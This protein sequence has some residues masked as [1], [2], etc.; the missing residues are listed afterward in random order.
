MAGPVLAVVLAFVAGSPASADPPLRVS[1]H[2]TQLERGLICSPSSSG[3]RDAPD[4][5]AGWIHVPD[6][7]LRIIAPS[8]SAPAILGMGF[9]VEFTIAGNEPLALRYEVTHPPMPPEGRT[10]QAWDGVAWPDS[11]EAIFFLFDI[12]EELQPGR[13]S[14]TASH[15]GTEIF[16]AE[17]DVVAPEAAPHLT[18]LCRD[19]GLLSFVWP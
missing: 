1:P 5:M 2:I 14:F 17:F 9:G 4:T 13:W 8:T 6:A 19:G 15:D 16:H 12:E 7:P 10:R 18:G 11:E 3:R